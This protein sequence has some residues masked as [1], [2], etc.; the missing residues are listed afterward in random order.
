MPTPKKHSRAEGYENTN[1]TVYAYVKENREDKAVPVMFRV[2]IPYGGA[3]DETGKTK[4]PLVFVVSGRVNLWLKY[5]NKEDQ[6]VTRYHQQATDVNNRIASTIKELYQYALEGKQLG[7]HTPE[8]L[9][10][11]IQDKLKGEQNPLQIRDLVTFGKWFVKNRASSHE[12]SS[13]QEFNTVISNLEE[14]SQEKKVSL[15]FLDLRPDTAQSFAAWLINQKGNSNQT[16]KKKITHYRILLN[17]AVKAEI[18]IPQRA[19]NYDIGK[20][21]HEKQD[22]ALTHEELQA[23]AML[24]IQDN[25]RLRNVRDV[26]LFLCYTGLRYSDLN[27]L[28]ARHEK[29]AP[30]GIRVLEI[31]MQKTKKP[32]RVPLTEPAAR[33]WDSY[34]RKLPKISNQK[35][36][37]YAK[38]VAQ[39]AGITETIV[40]NS[41]RGTVKE[42]H[43]YERWQLV[44]AHVGRRTWATLSYK[45]G[46]PLEAIRIVLGHASIQQTE[47]YLRIEPNNYD[48]DILRVW[49]N[50]SI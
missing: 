42:T 48:E 3:K 30:S 39:L 9:K 37:D 33:I 18:K 35:F 34:E 31:F 22:I 2:S 38:E 4:R 40:Q 5:W 16:V 27:Q 26:L 15:Q 1:V 43:T 7:C 12:H 25:R 20:L 8:S 41:Y 11:F 10:A 17:A 47:E 44:S 50:S 24:D 21:P 49:N 36:N 13:N 6:K 32:V 14:F 28:E 46:L 29:I 23:L 45:A 19:F